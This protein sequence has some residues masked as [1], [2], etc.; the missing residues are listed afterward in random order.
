[1]KITLEKLVS[2]I[3]ATLQLLRAPNIPQPEKRMIA[4]VGAAINQENK[5]FTEG[6]QARQ[7]E[8]S[9]L[10]EEG[11]TILTPEAQKTLA[12]ET[13]EVLATEI[14]LPETKIDRKKLEKADL[15]AAIFIDLE[16]LIPD[17]EITAQKNR[18]ANYFGKK[19]IATPKP[20]KK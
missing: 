11:Q 10:N 6:Y 3:N 7:K 13:K 9:T 15:P 17:V 14:E 5:L 20:N 8:L 18:T 12:E 16:W 19:L 1:M 4:I 2:S